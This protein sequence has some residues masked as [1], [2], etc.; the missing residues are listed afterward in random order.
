MYI[1]EFAPVL[2]TYF[3]IFAIKCFQTLNPGVAF[4]DN[5]HLDAIAYEL[6]RCFE[7]KQQRLVIN[8]A[9][10]SLKSL[11]TTIAFPAFVL[12]HNPAARFIC[13]SYSEDLALALARDFRL[14]VQSPWYKRIFPGTRVSRDIQDEFLTTANGGRKATS[15]GGSLTGF[16]GDYIIMDDPQKADE[17]A[18]ESAREKTVRFY[19]DTLLTRLNDKKNG[20]IILVSQRLNEYDLSGYV[21]QEGVWRHLKLA[22]VAEEDEA[23]QIGSD[24]THYRKKGEILH[25]ERE[26]RDV[27]TG[28]ERALGT[29][30]YMAQYQQN[31]IPAAGNVIKRQWLRSYDCLPPRDRVRIIQSWDTALK[32]GIGNDWSVCLT[33]YSIGDKHY[34]AN[35]WRDKVDYPTLRHKAENLYNHHRPSAVLI[36]DQGSGT[37]LIQDLRHRGIPTSPWRSRDDKPTRLS[38]ASPIIEAGNLLLPTASPWLEPFER[39]LLGFPTARHDDQVD[40]LSQFLLWARERTLN[41]FEFDFLHDDPLGQA[42]DPELFCRY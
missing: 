34:L 41:T 1:D 29:A 26:D 7:G 17:A 8:I 31:P 32:G 10:R 12:G 39:E 4:K 13:V 36:E 18:S 25:P 27:L 42:P 2:R 35:V 24:K 6:V 33:F 30:G 22:A 28:L 20:T 5:W 37:S 9:P 21:L 3:L 11:L 38:I 14:I 15:V 40:A 16:G 19:R 23:I